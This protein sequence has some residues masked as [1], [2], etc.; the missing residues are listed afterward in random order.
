MRVGGG[1]D[2]GARR[3]FAGGGV[4]Q[5]LRAAGWGWGRMEEAEEGQLTS[6]RGPEATPKHLVKD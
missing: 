3:G 6:S 1:G 4:V 5:A 2:E